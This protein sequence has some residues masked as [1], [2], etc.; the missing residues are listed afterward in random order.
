VP[1]TFDPDD[2]FPLLG[3]G[4]CTHQEAQA[5]AACADLWLGLDTEAVEAQLPREQLEQSGQELW[6]TRPAAVFLTPYVE[7]RGLLARLGPVPGETVVDLGAGYGRLG[8]VIGRHHPDVRFVGY[9]F[10]RERVAAA[11]QALSRQAFTQAQ[12]LQVDL[13]APDFTPVDAEFYFLYDY[14]TRPAIAKTLEDL[15]HIAA[16]RKVVVVGRGRACRDAID[17]REPWLSDVIPPEHYPHY[18]IYRSR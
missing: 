11:Q 16:R 14:G 7:L 10:V 8:F 13:T 12:V 6:F 2:P 1:L 18:S 3:A 5:H 15:R 4:E 9:E 17:R